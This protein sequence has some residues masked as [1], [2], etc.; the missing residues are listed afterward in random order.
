M[1]IRTPGDRIK[2]GTWDES[3]K[4]SA[5]PTPSRPASEG[6]E[7]R[8]SVPVDPSH[9]HV[10]NY[11]LEQLITVSVPFP[12]RPSW[13]RAATGWNKPQESER[14]RADQVDGSAPSIQPLLGQDERLHGHGE[15][16][17]ISK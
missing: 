6:P 9:S 8:A 7:Q 3:W 11:R 12:C 15:I 10:H 2:P 17:N 5:P 16:L 4:Q 13:R 1:R 14:L